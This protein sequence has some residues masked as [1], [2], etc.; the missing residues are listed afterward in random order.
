MVLDPLAQVDLTTIVAVV[1]IFLVTFALLRRTC[2]LPLLDAME[3]RS[4]RIEAARARRADVEARLADARH[5][6]EGILE[7]ARAEATGIA[8]AAR[9]ERSRER[10]ARIARASAEAEAVLAQGREEVAALRR[11]EDARLADEL[12]TCVARVLTTLVGSVDPKTVR[13]LV[14][15]A[16]AAREGR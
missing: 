1:A 11:S 7:R 12:C 2:F 3:R 8:A 10:E 16:L 9:E 5:Q 15:R 13:F 6:A 14:N 4:A